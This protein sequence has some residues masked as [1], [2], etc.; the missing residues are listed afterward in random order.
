MEGHPA[1]DRLSPHGL[2]SQGWGKVPGENI[3]PR[4]EASGNNLQTQESESGEIT[5]LTDPMI[6]LYTIFYE[7][8]LYNYTIK[9]S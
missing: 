2:H 5:G 4:S 8:F 7:V 9:S 3:S 6:C 1:V